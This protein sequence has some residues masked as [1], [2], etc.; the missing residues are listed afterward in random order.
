M[1]LFEK[2]KAVNTE[3]GESCVKL[4]EL[5]QTS[6]GNLVKQF[7]DAEA[8]LK[9]SV[10]DQQKELKTH[11]HMEWT[12]ELHVLVH[13]SINKALKTVKIPKTAGVQMEEIELDE[14]KNV[15]P[16]ERQVDC[17]KMDVI[18]QSANKK[19]W[20]YTDEIWIEHF[21]GQ[22]FFFTPERR[23]GK[24]FYTKS[25]F[26]RRRGEVCLLQNR[27]Y[28]NLHN[29]GLLQSLLSGE[30]CFCL[31]IS[32]TQKCTP[33][34]LHGWAD[35][36]FS[37][38]AWFE[39]SSQVKFTPVSNGELTLPEKPRR[40]GHHVEISSFTHSENKVTI[41]DRKE[42]LR[43]DISNLQHGLSSV[44]N[45]KMTDNK[46]LFLLDYRLHLAVKFQFDL[47]T[48]P[49]RKFSLEK[50]LKISPFS[51][52]PLKLMTVICGKLLAFSNYEEVYSADMPTWK[53]QK[54][55]NSESKN[56][57]LEF[58]FVGINNFRTKNLT[59]LG[60]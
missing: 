37:S 50:V 54:T 7:I 32:N 39:D 25:C 59:R 47:G 33:L 46:T 12:E 35:D 2:L 19:F 49:H 57:S 17:A 41:W 14:T 28:C 42:N 36:T 21:S 45:M 22:M 31:P 55:R 48:E 29:N 27:L 10:R 6:E 1:T 30:K 3:S 44:D 13:N 51:T 24:T 52:A 40:L 38:L 18:S 43:M 58:A 56:K 11:I 53:L 26:N 4:K 20:H 23:R 15:P 5:L 9:S 34:S 8:S 60:K 16:T